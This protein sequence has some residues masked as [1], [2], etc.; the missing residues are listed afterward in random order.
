[1][2]KTAGACESTHLG[3]GLE[4][5][6]NGRDALPNRSDTPVE[7]PGKTAWKA[8]QQAHADGQLSTLHTRLYFQNPRPIVELY[9]LKTDPL[10]LNNL[11]GQ[12]A[13]TQVESTLQ[14]ALERWM[15]LEHDFLPLPT[16]ALSNVEPR[17]LRRGK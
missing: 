8:I 11:A 15:I 16:Q 14:K 10:E 1:M 7:M 17:K 9:D 2:V 6:V 13:V 5:P 4:V 12:A 3:G